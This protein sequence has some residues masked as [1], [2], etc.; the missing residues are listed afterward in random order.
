MASWNNG[1]HYS[2]AFK[3]RKS[4][5]QR[6]REAK[7]ARERR[8]WAHG[9]MELW[10]QNDQLM[11]NRL[12]RIISHPLH[13]LKYKASVLKD[14]FGDFHNGQVRVGRYANFQ[15]IAADVWSEYEAGQYGKFETFEEYKRYYGAIRANACY[16][17]PYPVSR[18]CHV[19]VSEVPTLALPEQL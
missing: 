12:H 8:I 15:K 1:G 3:R 13:S 11:Y 5:E 9:E 16:A 17:P 19:T 2:G 10:L 4:D 18:P 14:V 6:E 7:A